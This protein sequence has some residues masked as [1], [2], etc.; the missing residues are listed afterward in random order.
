MLLIC[1]KANGAGGTRVVTTCIAGSM[2][3]LVQQRY[4]CTDSS[5]QV[6]TVWETVEDEDLHEQCE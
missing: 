3:R 1:T 6:K 5:G 2:H 4:D